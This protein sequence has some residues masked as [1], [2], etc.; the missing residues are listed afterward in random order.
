FVLSFV[1]RFL[2]SSSPPP[3]EKSPSSEFVYLYLCSCSPHS[4]VIFTA[5]RRSPRKPFR[6][7]NVR[8]RRS[9]FLRSL[10]DAFPQRLC[11]YPIPNVSVFVSS[12]GRLSVTHS[13]A[14]SQPIWRVLLKTFASCPVR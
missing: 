9:R 11:F 10:R 7:L 12:Q 8:R 13:H 5:L 6:N 3:E 14:H 2:T 4:T 1:C